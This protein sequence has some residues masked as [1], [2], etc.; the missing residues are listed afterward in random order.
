MAQQGDNSNDTYILVGV[1]AI[2]V[3]YYLLSRNYEYMVF[4]WKW[5]RLAELAPFYLLP[6]WFP[7][8]GD[9]E[10]KALF[11]MLY[12]TP[13][14]DIHKN[15]VSR[16][17]NHLGGW[18]MWLPAVYIMYRGFRR[19]ENKG[20][21]DVVYNVDT[22]LVELA[23]LYPFLEHYVDVH[24]EKM[25]LEYI[26]SKPETYRYGAAMDP[27]DF[28]KLS[29]PL[30]LENEAKKDS[31]L[32]NPIWDGDEGFDMDLAERAFQSQMG[33]RFTGLK[34]LS[35]SEK[36][37]YNFLM[38]KMVID[39]PY[40]E[41]LFRE[42]FN[43]ILKTPN[44]KRVNKAK[45]L[46]AEVKIYEVLEAEVTKAKELA[47]KKKQ[48]HL[49]RSDFLK[50]KYITKL[51]LGKD[52]ERTLKELGAQKVMSQH[53]FIRTGLMSLLEEA[54]KSGVISCAE[55]NWLKAEDRVMWYAME[56]VG[57]KVSF[58]ESS[59][60]FA[61]WLIELQ[62]GRPLAHAEVQEAVGGLFKALRLDFVD[63]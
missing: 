16:V 6:S 49:K 39:V 23:K 30:G 55:F 58:V 51:V 53:A 61:H 38:P 37:L 9:L 48:K 56:S 17:D 15:T 35:E 46:E 44:K 47:K 2:F 63:E 27:S 52:L 54:R 12:S 32:N 60:P 45:L 33:N 11:D 50:D 3:G 24:P 8:Y 14:Q 41:T 7:F 26:R 59:G 34:S 4:F 28:S 1:V 42:F 22:L 40:C 43:S 21:I 19:M 5:I 25:D 29:P 13:Y 10:V 62:L 18:L 20:S 36:K 57:R 31:K